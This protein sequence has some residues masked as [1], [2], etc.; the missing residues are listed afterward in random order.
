MCTICNCINGFTGWSKT[1]KENNAFLLSLVVCSP[2][3][4]WLANTATIATSLP[5]LLDFL[6]LAWP[7]EACTR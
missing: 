4:L 6:L 7:S 2:T 3:P 1:S 5:S